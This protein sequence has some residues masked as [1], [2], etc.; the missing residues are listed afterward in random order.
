L[1]GGAPSKAEGIIAI[2]IFYLRVLIGRNLEG[3]W[4]SKIDE[5]KLSETYKSR[6]AA[7]TDRR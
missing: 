1:I 4:S 6:V 7:E 3:D 5:P 2:P